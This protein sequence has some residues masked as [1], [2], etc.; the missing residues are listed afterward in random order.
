MELI[1]KKEELYLVQHETCDEYGDVVESYDLQITDDYDYAV[2]FALR[3]LGKNPQEDTEH[4]T[5]SKVVETDGEIDY[6]GAQLLWVS[7]I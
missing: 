4:L 3:Y 5:I 6:D 2:D 7:G 1:M